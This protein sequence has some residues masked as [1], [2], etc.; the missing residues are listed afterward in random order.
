MSARSR[1][2]FLGSSS[3]AVPA[4]RALVS[5]DAFDVRLVITQPD[6]PVGRKQILTPPPVKITAEEAGI[7]VAQPASLNKELEMLKQ[8]YERPDFLVVVSYGQILSQEVLDWANVAPVNVHASL[9][10]E[11]RGASPLQHAILQ[12]KAESG[13]T[14]QRMVKELD[15]GP[16]L[17]KRVITLSPR[18]TFT[19]LHN[20]L[21]LLG[22]ELITDTLKH[23]HDP[24][25]QNTSEATFC[26]KLKKEDGY[27]DPTTMNAVTIDRMIRAL[28]PWPGVT[29]NDTKLLESSLVNT[30]DAYEL[31]C[32]EGTVLYITKIQPASKKPMTGKAYHQGRSSKAS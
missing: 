24:Q 20:K 5:D 19:T 31:P 30:E 25:E 7:P 29:W 1:V 3:F 32:A 14:V 28:T 18:E 8:V 10:P 22:A 4:L 13:V 23:P 11:L 2:I 26:G 9:L 16:V 27:V 15:A 6:K 17:S 21:A 12:G